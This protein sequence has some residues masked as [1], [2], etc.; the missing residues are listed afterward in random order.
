MFV[1]VVMCQCSDIIII[2][3]CVFNACIF[4]CFIPISSTV[5]MPFMVTAVYRI[6]SRC[7]YNMCRLTV[8]YFTLTFFSQ[9]FRF[10]CLFR[11]VCTLPACKLHKF[12][13]IFTI[14]RFSY[15]LFSTFCFVWFCSVL[16][17]F[18]RLANAFRIRCHLINVYG[19]TDTL[20]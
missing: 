15:F 19:K 2:M 6:F 18:V 5:T 3:L 10:C 9:I 17:G 11:F 12:P 16:F 1:A 13:E 20:I 8:L 4:G 7:G 14:N